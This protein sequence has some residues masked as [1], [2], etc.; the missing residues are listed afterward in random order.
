MSA[1]YCRALDE[2][3]FEVLGLTAGEREAACVSRLRCTQV[4][5]A[6]GAP[7]CARLHARTQTGAHPP[8]SGK[9]RKS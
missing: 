4:D 1:R 3:V 5:R 7:V 9:P 6:G 2:V 8:V